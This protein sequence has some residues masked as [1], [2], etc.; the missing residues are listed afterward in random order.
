MTVYNIV[1][2][3]TDDQILQSAQPPVCNCYSRETENQV[4]SEG[5]RASYS[6]NQ[7]AFSRIQEEHNTMDQYC[8]NLIDSKAD[9]L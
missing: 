2:A 6:E 1:Q 7:S 4:K 5:E 9:I 3:G 8:L